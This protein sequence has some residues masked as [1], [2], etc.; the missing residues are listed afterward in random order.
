MNTL[1]QQPI[2]FFQKPIFHIGDDG[3]SVCEST[4]EQ[5]LRDHFQGDPAR[6][7]YTSQV[8][9]FLV[10]AEEVD[11]DGAVIQEEVRET[12]W[13]VRERDS[14]KMKGYHCVNVF[15]SEQEAEEFLLNGLYWNFSYG[16]RDYGAPFHADTKEEVEQELLEIEA[17]N[18]EG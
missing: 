18:N 9:D 10:K 5:F 12:R 13:E 2:E 17:L 7:W 6:E 4:L 11:D 15:E 8:D 16:N 3:K 1:K 14:H